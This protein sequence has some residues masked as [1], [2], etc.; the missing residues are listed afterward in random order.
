MNRCVGCNTELDPGVGY[1]AD[2]IGPLGVIYD[3][4]SEEQ[5]AGLVA[6]YVCNEI[7][8]ADVITELA[9]RIAREVDLERRLPF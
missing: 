4:A 5:R 1:I 9:D 6:V 2:L 7:C 3:R 8:L